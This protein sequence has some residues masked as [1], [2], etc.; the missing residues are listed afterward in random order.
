MND[1]TQAQEVHPPIPTYI[2]EMDIDESNRFLLLT[3]KHPTL[4]D[5]FV[6]Q[7]LL[8]HCADQ[9]NLITKEYWVSGVYAREIFIP[10]GACAVGKV[11]KKDQISVMTKGEMTLM[12]EDGVIR[13]KAPFVM[14]SKPGVKRAVYAHEDT[15]FMSF[16]HNPEDLRDPEQLEKLLIIPPDQLKQLENVP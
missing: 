4:E 2:G 7:D 11:H 10:K 9:M 13:I 5:I 1:L 12:T 15:I 16:H 14:T 6:L 8:F 3:D